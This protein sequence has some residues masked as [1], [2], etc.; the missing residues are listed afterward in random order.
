MQVFVPS[1]I[2]PMYM[3]TCVVVGDTIVSADHACLACP[4]C[5]RPHEEV[6]QRYEQKSEGAFG[7]G[8]VL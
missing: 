7:D 5:E 8:L 1:G 4:Q 3:H 6:R 2:E